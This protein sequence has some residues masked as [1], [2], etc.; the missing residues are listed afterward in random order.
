MTQAAELAHEVRTT[1]PYCGVGCGVRVSQTV[2]GAVVVKGDKEHP[3]NYGRLCSKGAALADTLDLEGR[4]LYPQIGDREVGWNEALDVVSSSLKDIINA[5]GTDAIAFYVSGQLLTEDY[6]VANKLM[7]GFI[8]SANIDTNSRLCMA[9]SV[10]GHRRAF[11]AD[12]VP[13]CYEDL[14]LAN[15]IILVGSNTAWCHPIV[16]QRIDAA[17]KQRPD[18]KVVVLDPRKTATC[19]I[20]DLHLPLRAG[21]DVVLFNGLLHFLRREDH[22]DFEFLER[23]TE[24]FAAAMAAARESAPS[25]PAVA[26]ACGLDPAA[27]ASF[28]QWFAKTDKVVTLFSQG[29]NQ[30]SSGTDKVNSIINCH[31]ATGR[32]GKPGMGPFSITGQPNAMGGREVGGLANQLAAHMQL[33][34]ARHREIVSRFWGVASVPS[35]PG[36]KAVELFDAMDAGKIK[37]VWIM[38]TNPVVSMP[39]ADKV[40]AALR[41]CELVIV[42]DCIADTDTAAFAHILLPAAPWGE[43]EGTVTNS[44]RRL[45]RQ[46]RFLPTAGE[47]RPDWWIMSEVAKRM[48]FAEAFNYQC[49]ADIFREHAALSG[50]E[51]NGERAFN[52]SAL[53]AISNPDYDNMAPV[54]WPVTPS[55]PAGK[56][57]LFDDGD[58]YTP[59]RKARLVAVKPMAP[60]N[61]VDSQYPLVLNTGRVRDQWHTMTRTGKSTRLFSHIGE[62]YCELHPLDAKAAGVTAGAIARLQTRWGSMLARAVVSDDQASG[63]VFVP[64]HWSRQ[65]AKQ[66]R[67]DALVNAAVDPVSGQPELKHTPVS[68][69]PFSAL[70]YGFALS[71]Q[72]L[73]NDD[74]LAYW[75]RIPGAH[76]YRYELS[77]EQIVSDWSSH[78][79]RLLG[80]PAEGDWLEYS[81]YGRGAFRTAY[82]EAGRLSACLFVAPLNDLPDRAWL[83]ELFDKEQLGNAE[84]QSLLAGKPSQPRN[85]AGRTICAC[86]GVGEKTLREAIRKE[87]IASVRALGDRLKAGTNCGSCIPE[88]ERLLSENR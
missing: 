32:I 37:A 8:G 6:Y 78:C 36:L 18:L 39:D 53:S 48:G 3:A 25:I 2:D 58:F 28:Y 41:K 27:V 13:G 23:H 33:E 20:A 70:W 55:H 82:L 11:G 88:L 31:L 77:G 22:L 57:R 84:R 4:L 16:Y 81:D 64:M 15:L 76:F 86:F 61:P 49:A 59:T 47:A 12:A 40:V 65:F 68:V 87:D 52:I 50:S 21:S 34:D 9:S 75:V 43:K 74:M 67:V 62:P 38:A 24:G 85:D 51:N 30:S 45:S 26:E 73:H 54:Q 72:P 14:E 5:H 80:Y 42:S 83:A 19:G 46:R 66:A 1:C 44:E 79:R 29:V 56:T 60:A 69:T 71:R 35:R 63:S 10:A 17:K 7:K